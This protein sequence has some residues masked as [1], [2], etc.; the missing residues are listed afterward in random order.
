[1]FFHVMVILLS[2]ISEFLI[3]SQ[4]LYLVQQVLQGIAE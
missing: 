1:M 3:F 2:S 4:S